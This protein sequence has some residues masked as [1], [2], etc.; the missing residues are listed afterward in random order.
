MAKKVGIISLGCAKNLVDSEQMLSL[1]DDAGY[2][3]V[4]E[5]EGAD[6]VVI[7]TCGFIE[8]ARDEAYENIREAGMLKDEGK[9][10]KIVV[11]GCLP[12]RVGEELFENFPEI[13]ALV[14]C[15]SFMEIADA[16]KRVLN[17]EKISLFGDIDSDI[18]EEGRILTTPIHMAYIKIAEGCDNRCSYCVIPSLRGKFRSR[19]MEDIISEAEGL[20]ASGVK[21][22][23]VV[24]QDTTRYGIDLYGE[25]K[26]SE[27]LK[28]LCK[29]E[30]LSWI[31][32]HYV[33]PDEIDD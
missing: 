15:G 30:G 26:I 20:A 12:Q 2:E 31:R 32:L 18:R 27:L 3:L 11:A 25:R 13:D 23:I 22:L 9:L 1:L 5:L 14:G 16:I 19:K 21:E 10:G 29:I 24:A 7:N 28:E 33:Y 4:S 8:S 6:A 17:D